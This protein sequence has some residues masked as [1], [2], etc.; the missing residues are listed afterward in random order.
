MNEINIA[1]VPLSH[2]PDEEMPLERRQ[3]IHLRVPE[4]L[5]HLFQILLA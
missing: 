4:L 3:M 5:V 1:K 2:L